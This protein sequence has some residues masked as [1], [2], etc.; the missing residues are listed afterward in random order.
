MNKT[1]E[2][3]ANLNGIL[4]SVLM[5]ETE[6]TYASII[7][8]ADPIEESEQFKAEYEAMM[9]RIGKKVS[10]EPVAKPETGVVGATG[11][12]DFDGLMAEE[13]KKD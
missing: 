12:L 7:E 3:I 11:N 6:H 10:G 8:G 2:E 13:N 4:D 5:P 1:S 9:I